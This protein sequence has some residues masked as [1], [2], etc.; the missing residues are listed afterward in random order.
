MNNANVL[1]AGRV[2]ESRFRQ[3]SQE[4]AWF[5]SQIFQIIDQLWLHPRPVMVLTNQDKDIII[6]HLLAEIDETVAEHELEGLSS[7][8]LDLQKELVDVFVLTTSLLKSVESL[9]QLNLSELAFFDQQKLLSIAKASNIYDRLRELVQEI[10]SHQQATAIYEFKALLFS[11]SMNFSKQFAPKKILQAVLEKN[12]QNYP[13]EYFQV[14]D[15][16]LKRHLT[17]LEQFQKFAHVKKALRLLRD[18]NLINQHQHF[19]FLIHNFQVSETSLK[20]LKREINNSNLPRKNN[21]Y[22][23]HFVF[24]PGKSYRVESLPSGV[25][26]ARE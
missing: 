10:A 26:L 19:A 22:G 15:P 11:L 8:D 12:A 23:E 6:E 21:G 1:I 3:F 24:E 4:E 14:F 5:F 7:A 2:A 9:N 25:V 17:E 16:I 13:A 18:S 20:R